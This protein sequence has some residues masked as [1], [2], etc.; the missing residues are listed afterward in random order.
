MATLETIMAVNHHLRFALDQV[1]D[2]VIV[3]EHA[4]LS[5]NGP[6]IVYA[7]RSM[8]EG[9]GLSIPDLCGATLGSLLTPVGLQQLVAKLHLG[10]EAADVPA[11]LLSAEGTSIDCLWS[12]APVSDHMGA[13]VNF[14]LTASP[15]VAP[16]APEP[17]PRL[18]LPT[19][20][21][22]PSEYQADVVETVRETAR[23]V[24]HEFRNALSGIIAPVQM[25]F[26][27]TSAE[28]PM[29]EQL[30]VAYASARQAAEL[31]RDFLDCFKPKQKIRQACAVEPLL[32]RAMRLATCGQKVSWQLDCTPDLYEAVLDQGEIERVIF[33][34]VRNACQA[35]PEGGQ[36][37]VRATNAVV[38]DGEVASLQAGPY[39]QISVRDFG[40]G[41]PEENL[42]H[43]F[44]S[45]FTTKADGNG[46]GLPICRQI[47]QEHGGNI[48]VKSKINIGTEFQL[49][50]PAVAA[51]AESTPVERAPAP[52]S[53]GI[54]ASHPGFAPPAPFAPMAPAFPPAAASHYAAVPAPAT[55]PQHPQFP[56]QQAAPLQATIVPA[57]S[58]MEASVLPPIVL[59][60]GPPSS[61]TPSATS[62]FPPL[63]PSA[64]AYQNPSTPPPAAQ[65]SVPLIQPALHHYHPTP[66]PPQPVFP[67]QPTV[68]PQQAP[69]PPP[70]LAR[71]ASAPLPSASGRSLLVIDDEENVCRALTQIGRHFGLETTAVQT[72]E[73]GLQTYRDRL[74]SG[75][76][77]DAVVLDMNLRGAFS[78][79]EVFAY[80]TRI[81]PDSRVIAT[82]GE[83]TESD[84]ERLE[85]MG[86]AGFLPKPFQLEEVRQVF[87]DV[88]EPQST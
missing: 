3:I 85:S 60:P 1:A 55:E 10:R 13:T 33:N 40:P 61:P 50:L 41:I 64:P 79:N 83:C 68:P 37:R 72:P 63:F 47:I 84:L 27:N 39:V 49:Y 59:Q 16:A 25:A 74:T 66:T 65:P 18:G 7:N 32:G 5:G 44:H 26:Q 58:R 23:Y 80:I 81:H 82:S 78:G 8:S 35:M 22:S 54:P 70:Q 67:S 57:A 21:P 88:L 42:R 4:P 76:P 53:A 62:G 20:P 71:A 87:S 38:A 24:A 6:S 77:Y 15:V 75:H 19:S 14:I 86:Y 28:G 45:C 9:S 36:L 17:A 12:V 73:L 46:C 29:R 11:T 69:Q 31:A 34:L 30:E 51:R 48:Y 43:L 52:V 2:A 56:P